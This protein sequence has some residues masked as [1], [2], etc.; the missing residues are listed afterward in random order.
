MYTTCE[1]IQMTNSAAIFLPENNH[2]RLHEGTKYQSATLMNYGIHCTC[3]LSEPLLHDTYFFL[4]CVLFFIFLLL[5][6]LL[7][8]LISLGTSGYISQEISAV[9]S[10]KANIPLVESEFEEPSV[11]S[12]ECATFIPSVGT[13]QKEK[14]HR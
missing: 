11:I 13:C 4:L 6:I 7:S 8:R 12:I 14:E 5:D 10:G 9:D 2:L 1:A 3:T